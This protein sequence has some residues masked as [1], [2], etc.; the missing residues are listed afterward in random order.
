MTLQAY[1]LTKI[2]GFYI[3]D[4]L[5][6]RNMAAFQDIIIHMILPTLA[7]GLISMAW[8]IKVTRNSM[9]EVLDR[10]YITT[11]RAYG[12]N[13]WNINF[14]FALKN[15][16]TSTITTAGSMVGSILTG[17]ALIEAIFHWPGIGRYAV[18]AIGAMDFPAL[19]GVTIV[20]GISYSFA[21]FLTDIV[22]GIF[23]PRVTTAVGE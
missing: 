5:L 16:L 7:L 13:A 14:K 20:A 23:D 15:A 21:N 6:T 11:A 4:A 8:I 1:P 2:T 3:V 22:Y 19:M 17:S 18:T 10:E 12:F 9:L